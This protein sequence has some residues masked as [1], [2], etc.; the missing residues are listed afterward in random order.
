MVCWARVIGALAEG[1]VVEIVVEIMGGR[2]IAVNVGIPSRAVLD[3]WLMARLKLRVRYSALNILATCPT[4]T[5]R[6]TSNIG[7]RGNTPQHWQQGI[8]CPKLI[9][10]ATCPNVGSKGQCA[11]IFVAMGHTPQDWQQWVTC[12]NISSGQHTYS[13]CS[14]SGGQPAISE[15]QA[16]PWA[17]SATMGNTP[18]SVLWRSMPVQNHVCDHRTRKAPGMSQCSN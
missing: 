9:A 2:F 10:G 12:F 7:K 16:P 5:R 3:Q 11:P 13:T 4:L 17:T 6:N 18:I 14:I 1:E 15:Q 8:A